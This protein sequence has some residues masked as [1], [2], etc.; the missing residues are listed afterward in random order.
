[1]QMSYTSQLTSSSAIPMSKA[2][3]IFVS[4]GSACFQNSRSWPRT[5]SRASPNSSQKPPP[6]SPTSP[7]VSRSAPRPPPISAAFSTSPMVRGVSF[8]RPEVDADYLNTLLVAVQMGELT[9]A[10]H[11]RKETEASLVR[12]SPVTPAE[13]NTLTGSDKFS[14]KILREGQGDKPAIQML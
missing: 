1:A 6:P 2:Y 14:S 7:P 3:W 5:P 4:G 11:Y 12:L 9:L 13:A 8:E 10:V